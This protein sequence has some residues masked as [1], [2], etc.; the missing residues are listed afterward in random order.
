MQA[1]KL[2][3][4][5]EFTSLLYALRGS[6]MPYNFKLDLPEGTCFG[7]GPQCC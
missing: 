7:V 5:S 4:L 3:A 6:A 2:I 1:D